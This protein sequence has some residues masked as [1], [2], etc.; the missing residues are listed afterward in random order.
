MAAKKR[1]YSPYKPLLEALRDRLRGDVRTI[2]D[3]ALLSGSDAEGDLSHVP[4]HLADKGTEAYLQEFDLSMVENEEDTL[5]LI[6]AALERLQ[7]GQ[8]GTCQ[9]CEKPIPKARLNAIPYTAY[10]VHCATKLQS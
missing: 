10:C 8:Y 1:D 6:D 5:A 9:N 4:T 2:S 7:T 3:A